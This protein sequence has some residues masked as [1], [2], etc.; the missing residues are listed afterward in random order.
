MDT[1]IYKSTGIDPRRPTFSQ[2]LILHKDLSIFVLT[3]VS[4]YPSAAVEIAQEASK[5]QWKFIPIFVLV[6]DGLFGASHMNP[7]KKH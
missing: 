3:L 7:L 5:R 4:I 6:K 2:I 1:S